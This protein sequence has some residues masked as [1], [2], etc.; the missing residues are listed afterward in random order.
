[1]VVRW[2]SPASSSEAARTDA[3]ASA[4]K[5]SPSAQLLEDENSTQ[6]PIGPPYN[7]IGVARTAPM[8]LTAAASPSCGQRRSPPT[9]PL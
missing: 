5:T 4:A 3:L 2:A 9:W 6:A 8:P 1:M 7:R